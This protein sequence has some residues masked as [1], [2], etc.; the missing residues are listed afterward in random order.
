[1]TMS[2]CTW[3]AQGRAVFGSEASL[4]G[5]ISPQAAV[6]DGCGNGKLV[7][8]SSATHCSWFIGVWESVFAPARK[9][10]RL[11]QDHKLKSYACLLLE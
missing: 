4:T 2:A 7:R 9:S 1:M 6:T 11:R 5:S 3:Q 8:S 10:R